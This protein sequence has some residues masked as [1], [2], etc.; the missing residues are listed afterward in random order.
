MQVV[1][2]KLQILCAVR[3]GGKLLQ[4][5]AHTILKWVFKPEGAEDKPFWGVCLFLQAGE[6]DF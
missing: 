5:S 6:E 3:E 1:L 4:E 2:S